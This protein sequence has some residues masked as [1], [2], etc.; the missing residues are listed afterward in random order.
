M[1]NLFM[2]QNDNVL[3]WESN[4]ALTGL[5]YSS[6][7]VFL[8]VISRSNAKSIFQEYAALTTRAA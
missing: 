3:R 2:K 6:S 7:P 5:N 1:V 8:C 4:D